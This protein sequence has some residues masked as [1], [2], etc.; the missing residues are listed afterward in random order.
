MKDI[1]QLLFAVLILF[2]STCIFAQHTE[3]DYVNLIVKELG[4]EREVSVQSGRVDILNNQYAIEVDWANKWKQSI[5]QALW[6][7][8]QTNKK[9]GIVLI[10]RDKKDYKYFIQLSSTLSTFGLADRVRVWNY[11]NDFKN[12]PSFTPQRLLPSQE[13]I[14]EAGNYW[15]TTSSQVRHNSGCRYYKSTRGKVG[16]SNDGRACKKCGG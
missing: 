1:F 12:I 13:E 3:S 11:P 9:A 16:G 4:G 8:Q 5:G 6:Y 10:L 7:A 15:I 14:D 2:P